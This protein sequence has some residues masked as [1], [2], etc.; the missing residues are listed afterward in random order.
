MLLILLICAAE[1]RTP[2]VCFI[3]AVGWMETCRRVS[4]MT[5]SVLKLP[6]LNRYTTTLFLVTHLNRN[7]QIPTSSHAKT[8]IFSNLFIKNTKYH[9]ITQIEIGYPHFLTICDLNVSWV[10]QKYLIARTNK[11]GVTREAL[12]MGKGSDQ[13]LEGRFRALVGF[14]IHER[15]AEGWYQRTAKGDWSSQKTDRQEPMLLVLLLCAADNRTPK[16][17]FTK[18]ALGMEFTKTVSCTM[19]QVLIFVI[20]T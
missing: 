11:L 18:L 6:D 17:K 1:N 12:A 9:T 16:A 13:H 5:R 3:A 10:Y 8:L 20:F 14:R 15:G 2:K 19:V 4:G 7:S